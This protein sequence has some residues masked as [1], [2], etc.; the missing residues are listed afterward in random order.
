MLHAG[1]QHIRRITVDRT[2]IRVRTNNS[3]SAKVIEVKDQSCDFGSFC[4]GDF[5]TMANFI[6]VELQQ[7]D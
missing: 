7:L 5:S 3:A 1:C 6:M 4:F 2:I